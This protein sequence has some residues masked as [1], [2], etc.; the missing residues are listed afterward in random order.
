MNTINLI[1]EFWEY[2]ETKRNTKIGEKIYQ[3][4]NK[5]NLHAICEENGNVYWLEK[6]C[7]YA[8][9]PNFAWDYMEKWCNKRGLEY[10]YKKYPA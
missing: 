1:H 4:L 5:D 7:S 2:V 6:T 3:W 9:I 10:L 8:T